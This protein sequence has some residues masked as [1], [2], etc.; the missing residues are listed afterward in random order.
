MRSKVS[1][2][3]KRDKFFVTGGETRRKYPRK[4]NNIIREELEKVLKGKKN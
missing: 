4:L 3:K 2:I 1:G